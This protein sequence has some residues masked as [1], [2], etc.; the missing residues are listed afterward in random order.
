[1]N[2]TAYF[3]W[4]CSLLRFETSNAFTITKNIFG[5]ER[6]DC[7][8]RNT[9]FSLWLTKANDFSTAYEYLV[10]ERGFPSSQYC[11]FVDPSIA[12][13]PVSKVGKEDQKNDANDRVKLP[14][15]P[16]S[17]VHLPSSVTH[18]L[19]NVQMKNLQMSKDLEAGMWNLDLQEKGEESPYFVLTMWTKDTNRIASVGTL[20]QLLNTTEELQYTGN[21][22]SNGDSNQTEDESLENIAR[23]VVKCKACG[24]V[25]ILDHSEKSDND[26]G[27]LDKIR[28][29]RQS[30]DYRV[31]TVQI[32]EIF[33]NAE[34]DDS[35][36]IDQLD[37][38][39]EMQNI[40][41]ILYEYKAVRSMYIQEDSI[42][43]LE[44]PSFARTSVEQNLP[45][46]NTVN[47]FLSFNKFW[48]I[49][50]SWQMLCSTV[51]LAKLVDFQSKR[52]EIMVQAAMKKPGP[53]Q[54][55]VKLYD[56]PVEVQNQIDKMEREANDNFLSLG[57]DP[58]LD[59]QTLL[60]F[61][62]LHN[63]DK[64][65]D[66]QDKISTAVHI[67]RIK[68]LAQMISKEKMRLETKQMLKSIFNDNEA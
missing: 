56:L 42:A 15:Y 2:Y 1:M 41:K 59:F 27:I 21:Q 26:D 11:L 47:D 58:C 36:S 12:T 9:K 62:L 52:D 43:S 67:E 68:Y 49:A 65:V 37:A 10:D 63:D 54:L 35:I 39:D 51:R 3:L 20:M 16:V 30:Y 64:D 22:N 29:F 28:E 57:M 7:V 18:T 61:T 60:G 8:R 44:L 53:L 40:Q 66:K 45:V 55:P 6:L 4:A 25:Q 48:D 32:L 17:A 33:P 50:E 24:I 34:S 13:L 46:F 31:G 14:I 23:I 38:K 5:Y 19:N